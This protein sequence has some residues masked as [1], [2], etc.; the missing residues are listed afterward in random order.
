MDKDQ[1]LEEE[2]R[3]DNNTSGEAVNPE[4][5]TTPETEAE[6]VNESEAETAAEPELPSKVRIM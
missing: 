2:N 1:N 6:T 3:T 5:P 4:Q